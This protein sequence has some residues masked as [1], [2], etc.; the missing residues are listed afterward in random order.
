L[1]N[2]GCGGTCADDVAEKTEDHQTPQVGFSLSLT[3]QERQGDD[4]EHH[5]MEPFPIVARVI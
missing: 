5:S 2:G 4:S 1:A 3:L